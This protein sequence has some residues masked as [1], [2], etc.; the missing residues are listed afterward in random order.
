MFTIFP[1][2]TKYLN[3]H[4]PY[5]NKIVHGKFQHLSEL[6]LVYL[7]LPLDWMMSRALP[8]VSLRAKCT[9]K[10]PKMQAIPNIDIHE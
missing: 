9:K 10:A 7:S 8:L 1:K 3:K 6:H 5:L 2:W 4:W